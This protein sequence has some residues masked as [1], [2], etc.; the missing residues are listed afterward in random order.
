MPAIKI[1]SGLLTNLPLIKE[2][3][4]KTISIILSTGM[5]FKNEI[6]DAIN[7]CK[8]QIKFVFWNVLLFIL[9]Q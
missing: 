9:H 1:S 7:V 8:K 6:V 5:A 3:T 2:A 4:F